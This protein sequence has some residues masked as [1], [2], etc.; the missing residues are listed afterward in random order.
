MFDRVLVLGAGGFIGSALVAALARSGRSVVALSRHPLAFMHPDVDQVISTCA[1]PSEFSPLLARCNAVIHVASA[2]TPGNSAGHPLTELEENLLPTLALL[3]ALQEHAN[4]RLLYVSSGGTLY[5]DTSLGGSA[6]ER[7]ITRPKSYYGAG[8]AAAENFISAWCSQFNASACVLRPSNVYG[9][10]QTERSGFGIVSRAFGKLMR[11]EP[12]P[13][14]GD[15][16]AV[17]DYLYIDDFVALCM[18]ILA[19]PAPPGNLVLNAASGHDVSLKELLDLIESVTKLS[20]R[21]SY[22]P[23]RP[24]DVLRISIDPTLARKS[25][26]WHAETTLTDGLE[27]TWAWLKDSRR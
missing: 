7:D 11:E 2:T 16:S 14:W 18:A 1:R 27:R 20:M 10:G 13:V 12:L 6:T 26:G 19:V 25:Y 21:R 15:G 9:P 24:V 8:K 3:D 4:C 23:A 22:E 17:R 5:G